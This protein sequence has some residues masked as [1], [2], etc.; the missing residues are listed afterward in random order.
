MAR[1]LIKHKKRKRESISKSPFGNIRIG[2]AKNI[3]KILGETKQ[4]K[5]QWKQDQKQIKGDNPNNIMRKA[6][7]HFTGKKIGNTE[8]IKSITNY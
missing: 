8:N 1:K 7:K 6:N 2:L 5:F 3:S 4:S